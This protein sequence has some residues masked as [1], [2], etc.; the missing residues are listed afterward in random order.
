MKLPD[1]HDGRVDMQYWFPKLAAIPA[2]P[3]PKTILLSAPNDLIS[4]LDGKLPDGFEAFILQVQSAI[5]EVGLPAFLRTGYGSG[6]HYWEDTCYVTSVDSI[7]QHVSELVE[8]SECVSLIGLPTDTWAVREFLPCDSPFTAFRG[9]MPITK[10]RRVFIDS[11]HIRCS[12]PYWPEEAVEMGKP[13]DL[14]WR[15]KLKQTHLM[16]DAD[17]SEIIRLAELVAQAFSDWWSVD[18]LQT[19]RGWFVIDMAPGEVSFHWPGCI[20]AKRS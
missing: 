18:F 5:G 2:I 3:V 19:R 12:H 17:S 6:K 16:S 14:A 4:V 8:W 9:Q 20:L 1:M 11:G 7:G 13:A 15:E 10:E